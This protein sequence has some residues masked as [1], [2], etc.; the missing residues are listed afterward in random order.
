M[1]RVAPIPAVAL[2]SWASVVLLSPL[3]VGQLSAGW[4]WTTPSIL[5]LAYL[6]VF[7]TGF[8][9]VVSLWLYR[10]LRPTTI[11]LIQV[12]VPAEAILIGTLWLGEPVTIR[13]LAGAALVVGA[14]ALNAIAGG[15]TPPAEE[16]LTAASAA[17]E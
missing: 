17:A 16:R 12:V 15:G 2:G 7:G 6:V 1:T 5:A 4:Y 13:M 8:A 11:T 10:K 14:V 3:A 9:M